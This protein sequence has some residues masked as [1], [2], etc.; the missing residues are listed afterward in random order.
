MMLVF[1]DNILAVIRGAIIDQYYFNIRK[2][3]VY[4]RFDPFTQVSAMIIIRYNNCD[5]RHAY[6]G[7]KFFNPFE[8]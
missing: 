5:Q 7:K 4:D 2:G 1:P 3:L 8:R 6:S